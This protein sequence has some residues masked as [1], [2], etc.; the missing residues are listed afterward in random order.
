[1]NIK[2][3]LKSVWTKGRERFCKK[4]QAENGYGACGDACD[5]GSGKRDAE[6]GAD[7]VLRE[8]V[9]PAKSKA[10][11][12]NCRCGSDKAQSASS[13]KNTQNRTR[14]TNANYRMIDPSNDTCDTGKS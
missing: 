4:S 3:K 5:I 12:K 11:G 1:M 14:P 2:E 7:E 8:E 6:L 13:K 9:F 10:C